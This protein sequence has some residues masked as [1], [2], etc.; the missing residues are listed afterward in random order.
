MQ[1]WKISW[2]RE[3]DFPAAAEGGQIVT[4]DLF[5][6]QGIIANLAHGN[7]AATIHHT[8]KIR[9]G[10]WLTGERIGIVKDGSLKLACYDEGDNCH[11]LGDAI[12]MVAAFFNDGYNP[13]KED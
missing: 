5:M 3:G 10:V 2:H 4:S 12:I 7:Y 13:R 9:G 1:T 6:L 11:R 8:S